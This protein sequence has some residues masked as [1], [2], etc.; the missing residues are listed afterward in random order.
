MTREAFIQSV[1]TGSIIGLSA[2]ADIGAQIA[3]G[4]APV[5]TTR[6]SRS[7]HRSEVAEVADFQFVVEWGTNVEYARAQEFGSGIH[8]PRGPH[9]IL[10]EAG[11]LSGKSAKRALAFKW[12]GAPAG[13]LPNA[14]DGE[15]FL[16]AR[17]HHPGVPAHPFLR[18]SLDLGTPSREGGQAKLR[19]LV[20]SAIWAQL[21]LQAQSAV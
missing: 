15:T 3:R 17:V 6:L 20:L 8:D 11:F 16:F 19:S 9:P 5:D 14:A 10:I 18:P 21:R 1:R 4:M 2:A 7:V 12:P 13:F